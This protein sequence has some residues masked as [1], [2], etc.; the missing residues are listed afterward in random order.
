MRRAAKA[1]LTG[2]KIDVPAVC[3]VPFRPYF[4]GVVTQTRNVSEYM[5]V[6]ALCLVIIIVIRAFDSCLTLDYLYVIN[7]RNIIIMYAALVPLVHDWQ[8]I[9]LHENFALITVH[10]SRGQPAGR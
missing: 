10:D 4:G 2:D 5:L 9:W 3:A 7:F 6:L 8:G 1:P